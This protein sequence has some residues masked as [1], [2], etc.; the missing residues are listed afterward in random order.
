ML[1][2]RNTIIYSV[3]SLIKALEEL[4][5]KKI[6]RKERRGRRPKHKLREYIKLICLKEI[7]KASLREAET[8][9]FKIICKERIDHSVIHYWEKKLDK[10]L[11]ETIIGEV[12]KKVERLLDY[13]FSVLDSTKFT[14]WTISLEEFHL[15]V[16]VN[17]E[18]VYPANIF[19]GS[20]SPEEVTKKLLVSGKGELLA[21]SW[22]DDRRAIREM[23]EQGYKQVVKPNKNR[24]KGKYR[25][26]KVNTERKQ[27]CFTS[28]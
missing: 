28:P 27:D 3:N 21:D 20:T 13:K 1:P 19:F 2:R 8:D 9:Y 23:F 10:E 6:E 16:R 24:F 15:L 12:G 7:K 14:S 22:Y 18:T 26:S 4:I 11:I 17:E 25:N 5:P